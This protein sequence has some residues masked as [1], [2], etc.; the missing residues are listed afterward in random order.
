MRSINVLLKDKKALRL[1]YDEGT[2]MI[3]T[4]KAVQ[5][6]SNTAYKAIIAGIPFDNIEGTDDRRLKEQ[7]AVLRAKQR[8]TARELNEEKQPPLPEKKLSREER[9]LRRME[10]EA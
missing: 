4:G 9:K 1:K 2:E 3:R 7:I 6:I 5:F 10:A 8:K